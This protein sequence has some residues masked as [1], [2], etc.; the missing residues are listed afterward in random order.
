MDPRAAELIASLRRN[1]D[2]RAAYKALRDHYARLGDYPSMANLVEGWAGR[3]GDASAAAR[4]Y[5]EAGELAATQLRDTIRATKLYEQAA[6]RDPRNQEVLNRLLQ[7]AETTGDPGRILE[8]LRRRGAIQVEARDQRGLADTEHRIGQLYERQYG[9]PDK[10]IAH[11]RKAFEADP[12]LI[13]AI[14]AAREIYNSAGNHKAASQLLELETKSEPEPARKVQ[15]LRELAHL[16][17]KELGDHAGA[18]EALERARREV[19]SDL[20]VM[21]EL[22]TVLFHRAGIV[23]D[24]EVAATDRGKAADLLV[25]MARDVP[26]DHAIAYC[27][28]ALDAVPGHEGALALLEHLAGEQNRS[29]LLPIR[30]VGFLQAVPTG[31]ASD[32]RRRDLGFAYAAA[33]Q[34]PDAIT[35]LEPLLASGDAEVADALVDLYRRE[36][37]SSDALRALQVSA[38]LR[39][40]GERAARLLEVMT[41]LQSAGRNEDAAECARQIL[42]ADPDHGEAL[43]VLEAHYRQVDDWPALRDLMVGASRRPGLSAPERV[44][45]LREAAQVSE[46]HLR[47]T[48][49]AIEA[50]RAIGSLDPGDLDAPQAITRLLREAERWDELASHL[51]EQALTLVDPDEK[52]A[53]LRELATLHREQRHDPPRAIVALRAILQLHAG[54]PIAVADLSDALLQTEDGVA[55]GARLLEG[56]VHEAPTT[57]DRIALL[58]RL[59]DTYENRLGDDPQTFETGRRLLRDV[60][61][62]LAALDAMERVDERNV[63]RPRLIETLT[64]RGEVAD[65]DA[66]V[67]AH[68]RLG[69]VARAHGDLERSST[70]YA[71]ALDLDPSRSDV[72]DSL[73]GVYEEGGRFTELV[74]V[75]QARAAKEEPSAARELH[76]RIA[77][78]L[79]DELKDTTQAIESWQRVLAHGE[80]AEALGALVINARLRDSDGELEDLLKRLGAVLETGEEQRDVFFERAEVLER[81]GRAE[82]ATFQLRQ[83][84]DTVDGA[85]LPSMDLLQTL[86]ERANDTD[87]LANALERKLALFEDSGMRLPLTKRLADI[88]EHELKKNEA[89]IDALYAWQACDE[90]DYVCRE[91][92]VGLLTQASR[93]EE[94]VAALDGLANLEP[95]DETQGELIRRAAAIAASELGDASGAWARLEPRID[96]DLE[97][98]AQLARLAEGAGEERALVDVYTRKANSALSQIEAARRWRDAARTYERLNETANAL[99]A[100]LRSYAL[101]LSDLEVLGEV[102]RL[103]ITSNAW[104]RLAQ[105]YDRVLGTVTSTEAKVSLLLRHASILE[106]HATLPSDAL[107]RILRAASLSPDDMSLMERA[108]QMAPALGR[109]DELL[110]V[111]DTRKSNASTDEARVDAIL[112]ATDLCFRGLKDDERATGYLA[113]GVVLS[114][115]TPELST[116]IEEHV[117]DLDANGVRNANRKLA[118]LYALLGDDAEDDPL[119]GGELLRRAARLQDER[120][121]D[122]NAAFELL[123]KATAVAS[124]PST[125]DA[126][127]A[128]AKRYSR[129]REVEAHYRHLIDETIDSKAVAELG[130]RQAELLDTVLND[131]AGAAEAYRRVLTVSR[132]PDVVLRYLAA[133][134]RDGNSQ[135]LL[136]AL[137]REISKAKTAEERLPLLRETALVWQNDLDNRYEAIDAWKRVLRADSKNEEATKSI[138]ALQENKKH[139]DTSEIMLPEGAN[140]SKLVGT[141]TATTPEA[142]NEAAEEDIASQFGSLMDASTEVVDEEVLDELDEIEDVDDVDDVDTNDEIEE[143]DSSDEFQDVTNEHTSELEA[144]NDAAFESLAIPEDVS[145][146][147]LSF[148]DEETSSMD[149]G[150]PFVEFGPPP[151]V[152]AAEPQEAS[153]D[154]GSL[155]EGMVANQDNFTSDAGDEFVDELSLGEL[156]DA[157]DFSV[158]ELSVSELD[159][160]EGLDELSISEL[161]LDDLEVEQVRVSAPPP[162]PAPP[163]RASAPPPPPRPSAP[164]PPP[165]RVSLPPPL[166]SDD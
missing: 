115:R 55:E 34:A 66:K 132:T 90:T 102:D 25:S 1:P 86:C 155:N 154:E 91:R 121:G 64:Y 82:D 5:M 38:S 56:R 128:H 2:D 116:R 153:L 15:L 16:R 114:L 156:Q 101:D 54:D 107:D 143:L 130:V 75:L 69:A 138:A 72:L 165:G 17:G 9:R 62:H 119:S 99:E 160:E 158:E 49:G 166:P 129:E 123:K 141:E 118:E 45:R 127:D 50:Y 112:R 126:L 81:L 80:D 12:S 144:P 84:L 161:S 35:C 77:R 108:E 79:G 11:Y 113:Q 145:R 87:G 44:A 20:A 22:S 37:R 58:E 48:A 106:T 117:S 149:E 59:L 85:H 110:H 67:E 92:L 53:A 57:G 122:S 83:L 97:A 51:D 40:P 21:H 46:T 104:P 109:A 74:S 19:P 98:D 162:P 33:G 137:K 100:M 60:P 135:N 142:P 70:A 134:R 111:Y 150:S 151:S 63:N 36:G 61:A 27:G 95:D 78:V 18:I 47:D 30:W 13:A 4:S 139:I 125:L 133:L 71:T 159:V 146:K 120:L 14:Y 164:P 43:T 39:P 131:A 8:A 68:V 147:P 140:L 23:S 26:T 152:E 157:D 93:H 76:R 24:P 103:A 65:G 52:I 28:S 148:G 7:L 96:F 6:A 29:D 136:V 94:L 73:C 88:Y 163:V 10:A 3:L 105:V 124:V 89:A 41:E 31:S 32:R 42:E